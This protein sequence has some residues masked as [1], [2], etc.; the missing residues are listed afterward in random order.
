MV[1][2]KML[3]EV[4]DAAAAVAV[5]AAA[6]VGCLGNHEVGVAVEDAL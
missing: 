2:V 5:V 4:M 6:A 1:T 3:V